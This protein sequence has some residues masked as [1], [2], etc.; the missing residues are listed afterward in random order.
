MG[1]PAEEAVHFACNVVVLN[2]DVVLLEAGLKLKEEL[3]CARFQTHALPM[4]E[5][6]KAGGA[7]KCLTLFLPQR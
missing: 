7:C 2:H 6:M 1:Q 5:F 3:G 4:A